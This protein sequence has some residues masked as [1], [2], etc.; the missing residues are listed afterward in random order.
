MNHWQKQIKVQYYRLQDLE[1]RFR[2]YT[3]NSIIVPTDEI[4]KRVGIT[5]KDIE[6]RMKYL[7]SNKG[8]MNLELF[9]KCDLYTERAS[10]AIM[11]KG[12]K[13]AVKGL[14]KVGLV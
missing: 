13:L 12:V 14:K 7:K 9:A 11:S 2:E 10:L 6:N 5:K 8:L 1:Q 3:E 4:L